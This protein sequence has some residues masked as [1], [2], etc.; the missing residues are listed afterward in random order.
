MLNKIILMKII[1]SVKFPTE[2]IWRSSQPHKA[3]TTIILI[4]IYKDIQGIKYN[5][6]L[7]KEIKPYWQ[8]NNEAI[9]QNIKFVRKELRN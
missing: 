9:Q 7:K 8:I 4:T 3:S 2:T 1:K 6:N 5:N